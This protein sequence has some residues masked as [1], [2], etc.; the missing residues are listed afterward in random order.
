MSFGIDNSMTLIVNIVNC[1]QSTL[2]TTQ[3]LKQKHH[4]ETKKTP[5]KENHQCDD[6]ALALRIISILNNLAVLEKMRKVLFP[7]ALVKEAT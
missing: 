4:T 3:S 6:D 1:N 7:N 2:P 5:T